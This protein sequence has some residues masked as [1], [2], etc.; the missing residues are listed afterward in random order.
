MLNSA[1][2]RVT[3]VKPVISSLLSPDRTRSKIT[4]TRIPTVRMISGKARP[5]LLMF[6]AMA[7]WITSV[8]FVSS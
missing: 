6:A 8:K 4:I 5:R 2:T 3:T 7:C 1:A